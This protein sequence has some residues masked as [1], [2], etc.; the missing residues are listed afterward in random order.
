[1]QFLILRLHLLNI[2]I[3]IILGK[4]K[5]QSRHFHVLYKCD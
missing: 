4:N 3:I 1:M 2:D 5:I